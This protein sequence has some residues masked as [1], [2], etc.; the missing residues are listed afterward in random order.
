MVI[1]GDADLD[2]CRQA[3]FLYF[4]DYR[5]RAMLG[6]QALTGDEVEQLVNDAVGCSTPPG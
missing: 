2:G 4:F 5:V 6:C 3:V 1:G